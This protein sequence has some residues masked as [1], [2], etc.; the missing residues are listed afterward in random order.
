MID[1]ESTDVKEVLKGI[2]LDRISQ[3]SQY[4]LRA[5]ARD[6]N[7][8]HS[9]LSQLINGR[10]GISAGQAVKMMKV[11]QLHG[12]ERARFLGAVFRSH[13]EG[14]AIVKA[15]GRRANKAAQAGLVLEIDRFRL[16]S[17]WYHGAIV[18]LTAIEGFKP[19]VG[20]IGKRLG[21]EPKTVKDAVQRLMRLGILNKDSGGWRRV[22]TQID[23]PMSRADLATQKYHE[24]LIE[25]A[26]L[27]L[28]SPS[29]A[30]YEARDITAH[31]AAINPKRLPEAKKRV[32]AFRK[33]LMAYLG[34]GGVSEVY[35]LN[36]QLFQL[37]RTPQRRRRYDVNGTQ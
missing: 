35:Q 7:I 23:F 14:G 30:D 22:H 11:L 2:L 3:N 37:S 18:E 26:K 12:N 34:K 24:Q 17:E 33:K 16:V 1:R 4:S 27:A 15:Q 13:E 8:S 19:N 9:Y 21:I 10:R 5:F 36:I 28:N 31:T 20:W 29:T 32:A 6:L 25:K